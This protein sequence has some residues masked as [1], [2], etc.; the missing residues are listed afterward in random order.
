MSEMKKL[1]KKLCG[2]GVT[3]LS[4]K[5]KKDLLGRVNDRVQIWNFYL[6]LW[7]QIE[8]VHEHIVASQQIGSGDEKL[9]LIVN[10]AGV[11]TL[12]LP[13]LEHTLR[14]M[15]EATLHAYSLHRRFD[16]LVSAHSQCPSETE[17]SIFQNWKTVAGV[18]PP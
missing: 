11:R 10:D 9:C 18:S 2:N 1:M 13:D 5:L 3:R 8:L 12:E 15:T 6:S 7:K 17:L 4:R 16:R 14:E